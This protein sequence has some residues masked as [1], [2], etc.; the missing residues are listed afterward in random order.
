ME[1]VVRDWF[2]HL[3]VSKVERFELP[4]MNAF[5]FLLHDALGG[6]G[7]ASLRVDAQGKA[8]AQMLMDYPIPVPTALA[9]SL[10]NAQRAPRPC[11]PPDRHDPAIR[12]DRRRTRHHAADIPGRLVCRP[13]RARVRRGARDRQGDRVSVRASGRQACYMRAR[14]R[15]ARRLSPAS[16]RLSAPTFSVIPC[17]S[18]I[19]R[20]WRGCSMRWWNASASST[21]WSTMRAANFRKQ[22]SISRRKASTR[23]STPI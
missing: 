8:Y 15:A 3:G 22:Q 20:R 17:R 7:V 14:C 1:E 13:G 9:N 4:G 12:K 2:A 16:C 23:S 10:K 19:P 6:G 21:C 11:R 18:A 5:N